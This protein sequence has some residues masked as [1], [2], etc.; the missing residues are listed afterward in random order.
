M[1]QSLVMFIT[2]LFDACFV[3]MIR[4]PLAYIFTKYV[5]CSIYVAYGIATGIDT[6]KIFIGSYLIKKGYWIRTIV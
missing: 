4:L 2:I 6:L 5:N 1:P 3:I